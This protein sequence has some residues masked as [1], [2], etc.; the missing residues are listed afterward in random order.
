MPAKPKPRFRLFVDAPL[1]CPELALSAEQ[2]HYLS[3]VLRCRQGDL[4]IVFNARGEEREATVAALAK[5]HS[6]LKLGRVQDALPESPAALTLLQALVKSDAM[7]LIVQKATELGV[8]AVHAFPTDFGVVRLDAER[9]PQ[10]LRHWQRIAA[11]A[12]EQSGRH[13]P[14]D[15]ALFDSID[16]AVAALP[17]DTARIAFDPGAERPLDREL[18]ADGRAALALGP[19]GGFSREEVRYLESAGFALVALGPRILR[20]ET[21]ALAACALAEWLAGDLGTG[22][23]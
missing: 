12:C 16:A 15:L 18:L 6:V 2:A 7:D 19:E 23:G 22:R 4:L 8:G 3:R 10:R 5:R 13:R 9:Q 20:A 1:D 14:P 17:A 21:A 11:G